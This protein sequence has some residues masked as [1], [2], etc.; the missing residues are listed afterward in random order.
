[1]RAIVDAKR[2]LDILVSVIL[3]A[4]FM[5]FLNWLLN[6]TTLARLV[7]FGTLVLSRDCNDFAS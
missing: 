4:L 3:S 5:L 7:V 2:I 1:M 6:K